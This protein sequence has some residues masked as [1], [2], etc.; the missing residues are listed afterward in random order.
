M[1]WGSFAGWPGT[2]QIRATFPTHREELAQETLNSLSH[3]WHG[4]V[5]PSADVVEVSG[6]TEAWE[7]VLQW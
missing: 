5:Y 6:E 4:N 7:S 2:L 3:C 1:K